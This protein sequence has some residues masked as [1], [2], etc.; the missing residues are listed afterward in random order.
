MALSR[1]IGAIQ[2]KGSQ[3]LWFKEV[4]SAGA[5]LSTPDTWHD[6]PIIKE[7]TLSDETAQVE[8]TDEGQNTYTTDGVRTVSLSG[9]ILQRDK[10]TLDM[11]VK[12][13]RGKYLQ[14]IKE[15]SVD[16]VDGQYPYTV[17]GV[18][19]MTPTVELQLPGGEPTFEFIPQPNTATIT[20]NL[21][22]TGITN[23]A[24]TLA[25]TA[26]IAPYSYYEHINV[27]AS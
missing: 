8:T 3:R 1:N 21:A 11:A 7:S 20:V 26:T 17:Y 13:Y 27:A 23:A 12:N 19:K 4:T 25:G 22:S 24:I 18:C 15:N 10:D 14:I 9:V 2:S 5:D 6:F 16:A